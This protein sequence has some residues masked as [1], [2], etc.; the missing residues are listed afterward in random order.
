M[1][2][3]WSSISLT[4]VCEQKRDDPCRNQ[5]LIH[6]WFVWTSSSTGPKDFNGWMQKKDNL[7][8]L[9]LLQSNCH[10]IA[11][12]WVLFLFFFLNSISVWFLRSL[13]F[14]FTLSHHFAV[15]FVGALPVSSL[16]F[17]QATQRSSVQCGVINN[18][19][20]VGARLSRF[21]SLYIQLSKLG[22]S[23]T[24]SMFLSFLIYLPC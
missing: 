1:V 22:K 7:F 14:F 19:T 11:S 24:P 15:A 10:I 4:S 16:S 8:W 2:K 3:S 20:E 18:N 17:A 23:Y 13:K 12:V 5:A 6:L 9:A 21:S